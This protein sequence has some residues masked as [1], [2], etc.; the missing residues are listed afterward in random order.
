VNDYEEMQQ[1]YVEK[2]IEENGG[3]LRGLTTSNR[4]NLKFNQAPPG[5]GNSI[6]RTP[7]KISYKNGIPTVTPDKQGDIYSAP[8]S[9]NYAIPTVKIGAG[10]EEE[11][12]LTRAEVKSAI[13]E[14]LEG[15]NPDCT[16]AFH[17]LA[18]KLG[19]TIETS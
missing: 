1:L 3:L 4:G 18:K 17:E 13:V 9:Q 12:T 16:F 10:D 7:G 14:E 15:A 8:G 6:N 5:S 2:V 19:I 11:G